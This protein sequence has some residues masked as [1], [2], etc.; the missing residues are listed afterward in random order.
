MTPERMRARLGC[1]LVGLHSW[2]V[3][4]CSG[5]GSAMLTVNPLAGSTNW[6]DATGRCSVRKP[7][8]LKTPWAGA[9]A[10][11]RHSQHGFNSRH[12]LILAATPAGCSPL[13]GSHRVALPCFSSDSPCWSPAGGDPAKAI[14]SRPGPRRCRCQ[15]S[16]RSAWP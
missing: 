2:W 6:Q 7:A 3:R 10:D 15:R 14:G 13:Q 12:S 16:L 8:G 9:L 4:R 5:R 1:G 11:A